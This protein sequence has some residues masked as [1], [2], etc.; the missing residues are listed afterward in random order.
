MI[1]RHHSSFDELQPTS[2]DAANIITFFMAYLI[3]LFIFLNIK[4]QVV[5]F[6][7]VLEF[8]A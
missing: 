4:V 7:E 3:Y 1:T 6:G 2:R 5:L 8:V